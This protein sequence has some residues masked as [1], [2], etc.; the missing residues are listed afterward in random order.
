MM[1]VIMIVI[2]VMVMMVM[3]VIV[4]MIV[5]M[6]IVI[7]MMHVGGHDTR[8]A[9]R[10][11]WMVVAVTAPIVSRGRSRE[12]CNCADRYCGSSEDEGVIGH[13]V[14]PPKKQCRNAHPKWLFRFAI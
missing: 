2:M 1:V 14:V 9:D 3:I 6:L 4:V 5:V 11:M 12:H 8:Q 13:G 7:V 10:I